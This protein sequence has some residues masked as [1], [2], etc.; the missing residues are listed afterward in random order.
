MGRL[1]CS[2]LRLAVAIISL[3]ALGG[4]GGHPPAGISPFPTR[5][6][7]I[8]GGHTSFQLGTIFTFAASA[9]NGSN[10]TVSATFTYISSDTSILNIAPNGAACVGHWDAGYTNCT[11][12]GTGVVQVT[13]TALGASSSPTFVFAH[14]PIDSINVTGVL[15]N[16][17]PIQEPCLSQGQ[18]MTVQAQAFS[19]GIDITS[20]VGPF[21]FTANNSGV[22]RLTPFVSNTTYNFAT[23]QA[24]ATAS[25]P[26]VTQI[27]ASA[28][29]VSSSSFQQPQYKNSQGT[30][31]VLDF[32][33]TCP[34]Q[35]ISLGI[36]PPGSQQSFQ[37]TFSTPKG[38]SEPV[39]ATLTDVMGNSSLPN[40]DG[41]V[42]L[43]NIPLSWIATQ[44]GVIGIGAGCQ[45]SCPLTTPLPGAGDVTASCSPPT[46]NL[47]FPQAPAVLSSAACAQFFQIASCQ[48]FIPV[49]VYATTAISGVVT[50]T[51]SASTVLAS[52]LGCAAEPPAACFTAVYNVSTSRAVAGNPNPLPTPPNSLLFDR[53]GDKVYMGSDFGAIY[54]SP[55]N[56]NSGTPAFTSLGTVTG[57]ILAVS[58]NG[59]LGVFSDTLHTPN[60]VFIVNTSNTSSMPVI[61]LNIS[62][63]TAAGFS[64]DGLK[65]FIIG[66]GGSS[67]Y[68][69]SSVQAL[70]G[71]FA[72]S[73]SGNAVQFSPNGAFAFV[74]EASLNGNSANLTAFNTCD[75]GVAGSVTLPANPILM[76][77]LPGVH[78]DGKD[79]FGYS[80]LDG[81]H[82]FVLDATGI[83]IAT[84]VNSAP[85]LGTLTKPGIL[86]PQTLQTFVSSNRIELG[87]GTIHPINF[88]VSADGSLIYV[89]A[90]DRSSILVY[91][92][93]TSSWAGGIPLQQTGT[94]N[95][96][97]VSADMTV[98]A[99]TI[100]VAGSDGMLHEVTT[101]IGGS[102][103]VQLPFPDLPNVLNP[104]C[105]L[106]PAQGPCQLNVVL[107]RP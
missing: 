40:T 92:F 27:Y 31:P 60:Q 41:G 48:P 10:H 20:S 45:Q 74:A 98:D 39:T 8:P 29:G 13:A 6:T 11:P 47:E 16:G 38:T 84:A 53:A 30:S 19:Q 44:P 33:E 86:C 55:G 100:V 7:L 58:P 5:I 99:A 56:L 59:A 66:N 82:I 1:R 80:I 51:T 54:I 78:I 52:S 101:A 36:G 17:V 15:L 32:F 49:P 102:D 95:V 24:T 89:V 77:V 42:V 14:P 91:D 9:Q 96:T 65:A 22:V 34:I 97:P 83:S 73:G 43:K 46:C 90:S 18:T 81:I 61:P 103:Q 72:L 105:N 12:G 67:L 69:Y 79:S 37:T 50:G 94:G 62:G 2:G 63:A 4:C 68:I 75:N 21:A 23:N 28:S 104:F 107:A 57:R 35:N 3:W 88:F 71:P 87:Q 106:D 93:A 25:T 76:T 26:G 64:Q 85:P 70:Q